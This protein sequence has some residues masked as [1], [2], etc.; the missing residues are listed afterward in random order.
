MLTSTTRSSSA[1][2]YASSG[3]GAT[4]DLSGTSSSACALT[5]SGTSATC[6]IPSSTRGGCR[7]PDS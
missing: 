1:T 7:C 6:A 4:R 3:T 5:C 2:S